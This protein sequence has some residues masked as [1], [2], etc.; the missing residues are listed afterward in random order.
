[1]S[2]DLNELIGYQV[3]NSAH[4]RRDK[5]E[6][7]P[8]DIRNLRAA[9]ELER[10]AEQI[11][12]L[13]NSELHKWVR[14]IA[15]RVTAADNGD[16]WFKIGE[17]ISAELRSIG[18]HSSYESG[19]Q[20]LEWFCELLEEELPSLVDHNLSQIDAAVPVPELS[21]LAANDPVVQAAKQAYDEALATA[22][23]NARKKNL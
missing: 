10:L 20:F 13:E 5:A 12:Q 6:Q 11:E 9:E 14:D 8:D 1:M 19:E 21:E 17:E 22:Y 3:Q 7:F 16:G 4:W 18:F 15:D 23:A 2:D